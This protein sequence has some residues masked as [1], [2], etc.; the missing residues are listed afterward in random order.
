[1]MTPQL[2]IMFIITGSLLLLFLGIYIVISNFFRIYHLSRRLEAYTIDSLIEPGSSVG[3]TLYLVGLDIL[4]RLSRSISKFQIFKRYSKRYETYLIQKETNDLFLIEFLSKKII[5]ASFFLGFYLFSCGFH[6]FLPSV[7]GTLFFILL[8]FFLPDIY[9]E[10]KKRARIHQIEE[11]LIKAITIM[12]NSLKAGKS[13]TQSLE[14]VSKEIVGPLKE[15]FDKMN[16]DLKFGLDLETVF[17]R[18][19]HRVPT[20]DVNY[21]TTSLIILNRTGG[22]ISTIFESIEANFLE[23]RKLIQELK[24]TTASANAIFKILVS[25]P[26]IIVLIIHIFNRTYFE[27]FFKSPIGYLLLFL[28]IALYLIYLVII[29]NIMRIED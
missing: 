3:D 21:I 16:L 25:L 4:E 18:F 29:H 13:I 7:F 14:A 2:S 10:S 5:W 24:A 27:A 15:E 26:F 6:I 12:G 17:E 1:M 22:D 20:E 19:S 23:R 11:D 8:G 9:W 28:T